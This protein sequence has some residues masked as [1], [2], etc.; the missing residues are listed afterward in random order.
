MNVYE[1]IFEL[2]ANE[3]LSDLQTI[4][5]AELSSI[6]CLVFLIILIHKVLKGT[7]LKGIKKLVYATKTD[8]DDKL[9][10]RG[11]FNKLTLLVP[12]VLGQMFLTYF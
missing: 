9:F 5:I 2:L 3:N 7:M 1:N 10:N 12:W 6:A 4:Y 11:I 8:W